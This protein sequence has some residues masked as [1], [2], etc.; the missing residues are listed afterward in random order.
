MKESEKWW[1]VDPGLR[2]RLDE[3]EGALTRLLAN[4]QAIAAQA[5]ARAVLGEGGRC[6]ALC[7]ACGHAFAHD[8]KPLPDVPNQQ[9]KE[10]GQ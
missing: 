8:H 7:P 4:P 3:L 6:Q 1:P 10:D 9:T 5:N 2:E